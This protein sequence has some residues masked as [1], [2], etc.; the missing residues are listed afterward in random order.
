MTGADRTARLVA[1]GAGYRA[2]VLAGAFS[3][4]AGCAHL[5][6]AERESLMRASD[7][8]SRNETSS[9]IARLDRLINDFGQA[10]EI[11]EAYYLRGL[12]R[13]R[14][15]ELQA[16]SE[17]F[18]RAVRKSKRDDLTARCKASL[19][20]IAYRCGDWARAAKLYGEAVPDL[21]DQ[22]PTDVILYYTGVA[23]RRAGKWEEA[24]LQFARIC[25]RF[26]HRSIVADVRRLAGWRHKH[27]A[28][29]LGAF[30]DEANAEKALQSFR[31]K[32]LDHLTSEN[33]PRNGYA[34]WVVMAGRYPTYGEA[35]AALAQVRLVEPKAYI[36]PQ[37]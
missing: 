3:V 18:E 30:K 8:Y 9:A 36:I 27:Y 21:P 17:D 22:P 32:R 4:L 12:C 34:L 2:L 16:A 26:R 33:L 5:G 29:Q 14:K 15:G 7:L 35:E 31:A 13:T 25:R 10:V 37:P 28:I 6:P 1:V 24:A 19:A 11:S 20:A 23:M